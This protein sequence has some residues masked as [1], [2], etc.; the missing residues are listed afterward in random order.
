MARFAYGRKID[1]APRVWNSLEELRHFVMARG[2]T[3]AQFKYAV[4]IMGTEPH[5][6]A[7]YLQRHEFA[8]GLSTERLQ[9]A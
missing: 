7:N 6:I 9:V 8:V 1:T 3:P 5:H 4:E 2:C